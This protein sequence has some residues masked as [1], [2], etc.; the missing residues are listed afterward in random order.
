MSVDERRRSELFQGLA[1]V[2]GAEQAT[3][4]FE[5]MPPSGSEVA[6]ST[7]IAGLDRRFDAVGQ[8]FAAVD[9]R[10]AEVDRR[11]DDMDRRF[12]EL[13]RRFDERLD[14]RLDALRSDVIA[15]FRGELNEVV[16]KQLRAMVVSSV[17]TALAVTGSAVALAQVL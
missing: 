11:F 15:A 6:T 1:G 14:D 12:D 17:S 7:D 9:Q 3:T 16:S 5:L 13:E 2:I 4:M 10:F 8:R